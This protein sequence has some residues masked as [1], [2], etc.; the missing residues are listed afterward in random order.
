[1]IKK[2]QFTQVKNGR[3]YTYYRK[4]LTINGKTRTITAANAKEWAEKA[5]LAKREAKDGIKPDERN[6]TIKQLS[7]VFKKDGESYAPKTY[8]E[9][10]YILRL[11]IVP[12]LGHQKLRALKNL[13]IREF[14]DKV[15]GTNGEGIKKLE[16]VHKVLNRMLN[17]AVENETGISR[18]PISKGLIKSIKHTSNRNK[19]EEHQELELS[20]ED[21]VL[22]L[23]EVAGN[24]AEIIFHLQMLHGLR[25]GEALGMTWEN[26]DLE[27]NTITV[28]Q[29]LQDISMKLRKGTR[30]ESDSYQIKTIPKTVRSERNVPLQSPT[31]K[32][33]LRTAASERNGY[34][35]KGQDGKSI[36]YGNFRKRH[37][38]PV[39]RAL[40]LKL[41][42]HDLRT[43]FG[44]W[45]LGMNRTDIMTVSKWMGHRD[46]RVTLSTYAKVIEELEKEHQDAIGNALVPIAD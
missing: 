8:Q 22:L 25:I 37:F 36:T 17:W 5:E 43:F 28:N 29:Q 20:Y 34:V 45:H 2:H 39:I 7:E 3:T 21:A 19:R 16:H 14:Y 42:T 26:I 1:M 24:P 46:P 10:E 30:F 11:Y 44:S 13:H 15:I 32:M 23:K 4:S 38:Y 6:L 9:R 27:N 40:D 12:E 35:F 31:K 18:N 33:L 41:K